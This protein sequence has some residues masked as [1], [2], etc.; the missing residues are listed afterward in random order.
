MLNLLCYILSRTGVW[1]QTR[2]PIL[3]R[4][5]LA[6]LYLVRRS[7]EPGYAH[8]GKRYVL[9]IPYLF[10]ALWAL[11][12]HVLAI[13]GAGGAGLFSV[14]TIVLSDMV[15]LQERGTYNGILQV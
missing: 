8:R 12:I 3:P 11:R 4:V 1:T 9:S 2:A 14:S 7:A 6:R 15:P 13:Q 10:Q 5:I